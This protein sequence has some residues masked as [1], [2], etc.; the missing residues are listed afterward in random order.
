MAH[1]EEKGQT[2]KSKGK[3][4]EKGQEGRARRKGKKEGQ[5]EGRARRKGKKD[6][7]LME[8]NCKCGRERANKEEKGQTRK[9]KGK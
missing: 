6:G 5:E 1:K 9:R 4:E 7:Q 3:K 8:I 2:R